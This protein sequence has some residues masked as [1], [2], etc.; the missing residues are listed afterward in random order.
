MGS[1]NLFNNRVQVNGGMRFEKTET[2]S[3]GKAE[4]A[5][6]TDDYTTSHPSLNLRWDITDKLVARVAYANTIGRQ[7]YSDLIANVTVN[8]PDPASE[9][10]TGSVSTNNPGLKPQSADNYD[11]TLEYYTDNAGVVSVGVF[12]KEITDYM[13]GVAVDV[14]QD[15]IDQYNLPQDTLGFQFNTKENAGFAEVNGLELNFQQEL[16]FLPDALKGFAVFANATFL[17]IEGNFGGTGIE[18]DLRGFV[19][20]TWN[21]GVSFSRWNLT[22]NL[23]FTHKGEEFDGANSSNELGR[24]GDGGRYFD[25][26]DHMDFDLEYRFNE[27]YTVYVSARNMLNNPQN[28]VLK[29]ESL[30][31]HVLTR[32]EEFGVQYSVG[33]K[34]SF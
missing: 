28:Q 6:I 7:E 8:Y 14:D 2:K 24:N 26:F 15:I 19:K 31:V 23:K 9:D 18:T 13:R 3:L 30:G 34:G 11:M 33:V 20:E 4:T 21:Y 17:D 32:S 1:M 22:T 16:T 25:P 10:P 29:S 27:R 12:R 5:W